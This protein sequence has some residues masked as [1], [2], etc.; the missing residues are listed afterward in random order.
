MGIIQ[1]TA[2]DLGAE[3]K[4]DEPETGQYRVAAS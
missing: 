4:T 2:W 3:P 1:A